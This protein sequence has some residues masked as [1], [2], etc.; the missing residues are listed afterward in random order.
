MQRERRSRRHGCCSWCKRCCE[1]CQRRSYETRLRAAK[2]KQQGGN[3]A[4]PP[5]HEEPVEAVSDLENQRF[6]A[7][8][9]NRLA[10]SMSTINSSGALGQSSRLS[11]DD[12]HHHVVRHDRFSRGLSTQVEEPAPDSKHERG[13]EDD[14]SRLKRR[15]SSRLKRR[16]SSRLK[17]RGSSRLKRRGSSRLKRRGSSRLKRRGSSRLK[18]R[19]SSR[20]KRRE[21]GRRRSEST[22]TS[23]RRSRSR[24]RP[25]SRSEAG[26]SDY[27]TAS[28][29]EHHPLDDFLDAGSAHNSDGDHPLSVNQSSR[30]PDM[31][32]R[33]MSAEG[34]RLP[35]PVNEDSSVTPMS[36]RPRSAE[37]ARPGSASLVR[38]PTASRL[39]GARNNDFNMNSFLQKYVMDVPW[40]CEWCGQHAWL[41]AFS[42]DV[43]VAG[44]CT[45]TQRVGVG[46]P[47]TQVQVQ[48]QVQGRVQ[49]LVQ[50][51]VQVQVQA[52]AQAQ[53][54]VRV[55]SVW[56][57]P[58]LVAQPRGLL[59]RGLPR[60]LLPG[61]GQASRRRRLV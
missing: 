50:V 27:T 22:G 41:W 58:R 35:S 25:R 33:S 30:L 28:E 48:A 9:L 34:F 18:R 2:L 32:L 60:E 7:P 53:V 44:V 55:C 40:A 45:A 12:P 20:L 15:G 47:R 46:R 43:C 51:L 42:P 24:S 31:G 57:A 19:G 6:Q 56:V 61:L 21:S 37:A 11:L 1:E 39:G 4:V 17:R 38:K 52:Q 49:V 14:Q 59:Y 5:P 3:S 8:S 54:Q 23:M 26:V 16:G 29:D 13:H 10:L 36:G